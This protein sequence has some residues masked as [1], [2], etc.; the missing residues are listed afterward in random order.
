MEKTDSII[1]RKFV[2]PKAVKISLLVLAGLMV[3]Y[4]AYFFYAVHFSLNYTNAVA[5]RSAASAQANGYEL[6]PEFDSFLEEHGYKIEAPCFGNKLL[7]GEGE[8]FGYM[9]PVLIDTLSYRKLCGVY[10]AINN[11]IY[12]YVK[13][14]SQKS[15]A[16]GKVGYTV[17]QSGDILTVRF[18]GELYDTDGS[19]LEKVDKDFVFD[20]KSASI[21]NAPVLVG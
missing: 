15:N 6:G 14:L 5:P 20:V 2:L 16:L 10:D 21:F 19:V 3:M 17:E 1:R 9:T 4:L 11:P 7:L 12:D 8:G 13:D 18:T